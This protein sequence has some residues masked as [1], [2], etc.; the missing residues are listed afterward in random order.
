[1]LTLATILRG[2]VWIGLLPPWQGPDEPSH[3]AFVERL[4]NW[5]YPDRAPTYN[6]PSAALEASI[7]HTGFAYFLLHDQ[8]RPFSA[9][10]RAQL[11][12]E[13]PDLSQDAPSSLTTAQ[14]PP[15]YYAMLVP[16]YRLPGLHTAT[17]RLYAVRLGSALFGGLLVVLTFFLIREL[18]P[19]DA[20]AL[21][22]AGLI[23]LPPMVSQASAIC[24]PDIGL[25]AACAA[26]ALTALSVATRGAT[27]G[28]L[29][30]VVAL[31]AATAL[32]K[33]FGIVAAAVIAGTL[34]GLPFL[35]RR[36]GRAL[37]SGVAVVLVA[38]AALFVVS[39]ARFGLLSSANLRF[40]ADYLWDFYLPRLPFTG[41]I[42]LPGSPLSEP[43][44]AWPIWG[45]TGVGSFGWISA[46]LRS[47]FVKLGVVSIAAA[48]LVAAAG[49]I[50]RRRARPRW[51]LVLVGSCGAAVL[52]YVVGLH[53]AEA[54]Q[55][56]QA[57]GS[58][59]TLQGRIL[60]GRYLIPIA[61]LALAAILAGLHAWSRRVAIAAATVLL[62]VWIAISVA[63]LNT[64][65]HFYAT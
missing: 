9:E 14:Y 45:Q 8:R 61:P 58:T 41:P 11:S 23:S 47:E 53:A 63:G 50:L 51:E 43:V 20:L 22:G 7:E 34:L 3:Y 26:L 48:M 27:R 31:A 13:P 65:L 1:L 57:R 52:L 15:L 60:Q 28:R 12:A 36:T 30:T 49:L 16:L 24:N 56:L 2:I 62:V 33:P 32:M 17:N 29:L 64:V 19:D 38:G 59:Q 44:P 18:V 35:S 55:V 37:L 42:F 25:A 21:A 39:L 10:L 5:S 4:A 6:P 54:A 40:S 46:P